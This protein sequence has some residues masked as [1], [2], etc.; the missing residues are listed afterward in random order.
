MN[1]T[2]QDYY[3]NQIGIERFELRVNSKHDEQDNL[4]DPSSNS[5]PNALPDWAELRAQV[6]ACQACPLAESRNK[7]VFGAGSRNASVLVVGEAP[8]AD[9][10]REGEPFV[11]RAGRL[12]TQMLLATG[13]TRDQVYITNILKCRPPG[14]RDPLPAEVAQCEKYLSRQIDLLKPTVILAIGRI[15]AQNLLHTETSI[16]ALRG[17]THGWGEQKTPVIVTYHPA[18]LL[19]QPRAKAEAWKDLLQLIRLLK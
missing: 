11:G 17:K 12:L 13:F 19:R 3:L 8:G 18:Y 2:L 1:E 9:E 10:D 16:G 15:A 7:T 14:N 6:S 5:E 4:V